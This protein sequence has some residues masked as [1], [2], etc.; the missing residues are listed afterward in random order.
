MSLTHIRLNLVFNN[1][2]KVSYKVE[3]TDFTNDSA[4]MELGKLHISK[5]MKKYQF[6]EST[7]A[8]ENKLISPE[9]YGF[10]DVERQGLLR[11]KYSNYGCGAWSMCIHH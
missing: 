6:V 2:D 10:S 4:W 9:L 8:K 11:E 3:S 5:S 1:D 7:L